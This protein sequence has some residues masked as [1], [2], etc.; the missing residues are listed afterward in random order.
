M[1]Y[2]YARRTMNRSIDAIATDEEIRDRYMPRSCFASGG[3]S[4]HIALN[5][6]SVQGIY[7]WTVSNV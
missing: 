5:M 6:R 7:N 1:A 4:I 2:A 3:S